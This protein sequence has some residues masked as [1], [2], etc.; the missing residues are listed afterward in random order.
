M[1]LKDGFILRQIGAQHIVV[2]VGAQTVDFDCMLTL[3]G[4]GALLWQKL[5]EECTE[6]EL[7]AALLAEYDVSDD[8]ARADVARFVGSLQEAALLR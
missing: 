5:Q 4:T 7:V 8:T 3:N 1:K 6:E 2:P